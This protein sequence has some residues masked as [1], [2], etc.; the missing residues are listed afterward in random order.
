MWCFLCFPILANFGYSLTENFPALEGSAHK[1][2]VG[3]TSIEFEN[4]RQRTER[5]EAMSAA[6][7][8]ERVAELRQAIHSQVTKMGIKEQ[9]QRCLADSRDR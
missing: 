6:L 5:E 2:E 7:P 9:I 4:T 3:V 1:Q 8:A